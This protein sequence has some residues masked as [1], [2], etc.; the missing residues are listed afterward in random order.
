MWGDSFAFK[1]SHLYKLENKNALQMQNKKLSGPGHDQSSAIINF[2]LVVMQP[3][4]HV[5][6][7]LIEWFVYQA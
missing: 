2:F 3:P 4:V 6:V 5:L 1:C 7:V